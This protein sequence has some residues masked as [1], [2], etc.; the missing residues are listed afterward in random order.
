MKENNTYKNLVKILP[1]AM[2]D[3]LLA[4][5][6]CGQESLSVNTYMNVQIECKKL[7]CHTPEG[8]TKCHKIHVGPK[9]SLCPQLLVHGTKMVEVDHDTYLG[10][11]VTADGKNTMN[12]KKR[13]SKGIG[14]I[15]DIMN[16]LERVTFGEYYFKI[17]MVLR[18]S[19]FINGIL[20]N[21]EIWYGLTEAETNEI[22][23]LDTLLLRKILNTKFSVL[24]ESLYL[25]LG[26][27]KIKQYSRLEG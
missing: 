25:E 11:I 14:I 21:T 7:K 13:I 26:C 12:I 23:D 10:D 3:D 22:E 19:K 15:S 20:T 6:P 1:L 18:E 24:K 16:I 5:A 17:A 4:I 8:K 2:V 9:T 27:L